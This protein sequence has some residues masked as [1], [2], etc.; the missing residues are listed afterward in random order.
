MVG[1]ESD[2][3]TLCRKS[4]YQALDATVV[5]FSANFGKRQDV[6]K[7]GVTFGDRSSNSAD[8]CGVNIVVVEI[9][10]G[11]VQHVFLLR[12]IDCRGPDALRAGKGR[13]VGPRAALPA[14]RW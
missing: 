6:A 8:E 11:A 13:S 14:S 7:S 9:I 1:C 4:D 12:I 10:S 2:I 5:R 3:A